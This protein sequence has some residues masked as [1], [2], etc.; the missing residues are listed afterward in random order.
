ML[1]FVALMCPGCGT[2]TSHDD[3]QGLSDSVNHGIYRGVRT[4]WHW[5]ADA[6]PETEMGDPLYCLDMPF[7]FVADT[8][9]LPF[10]AIT[11]MQKS[12]TVESPAK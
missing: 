5:V 11:A 9:C 2:L 12:K 6:V 4:D 7:S 3:D 1:F 10:D 8:L